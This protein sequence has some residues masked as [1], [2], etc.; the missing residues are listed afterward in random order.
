MFTI[1]YNKLLNKMSLVK[2]C[3]KKGSNVI[4]MGWKRKSE[5][6]DKLSIYNNYYNRKKNAVRF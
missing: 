4:K 6:H 1:I 2:N 3:G 5:P